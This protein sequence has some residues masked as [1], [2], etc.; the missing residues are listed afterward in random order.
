M[1]LLVAVVAVAT[2][3]MACT[4]GFLVFG[5]RDA[6]TPSAPVK[7]LEPPI[8]GI[9]PGRERP[10]LILAQDITYPP[11]AFLGGSDTDFA[12]SGFGHDFA[13]G[14][15]EVCDI[16]IVTVQTSWDNCWDGERA[17]RA[18][19][20]G[21]FHAC[22]T[23]THLRGG[24]NRFLEFSDPIL[25]VNKP[26]GILTRLVDGVPVVSSLSDLAG[27]KVAEVT[28]WAPTPDTL[29]LSTNKCTG[30]PFHGYEM[31]SPTVPQGANA[32]D[33]S[34]RMLLEGEVDALWIY[35][36]QAHLYQCGDGVAADWNCS[37]WEGFGTKYAYIQTGMVSYT[38]GGTTLTMSKKGSGIPAIVNPCIQK[39]KE[40]KSYFEI[41]QKH[42]LVGSCFPNSHFSSLPKPNIW[43]IQAPQLNTTCADGYCSCP[44]A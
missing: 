18:L 14:M 30:K 1:R 32:N 10:K 27:K 15:K 34:M 8:P 28:G 2:S 43:E 25:D 39:F 26:A 23:F 40:T 13:N 5:D 22:M 37:L 17:G 6:L 3:L 35:A 19:A 16:D 9:M 24:R 20:A 12:L 21:E 33:V 41:C 31:I 29:A 36:D 38:V 42:D 4:L 7:F 44:E 11:F